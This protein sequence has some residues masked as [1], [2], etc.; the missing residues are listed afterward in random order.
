MVCDRV[1]DTCS[2]LT[3]ACLLHPSIHPTSDWSIDRYSNPTWS[4]ERLRLLKS[5]LSNWNPPEIL[6]FCI[7]LF[8]CRPRPINFSSVTYSLTHSL[9]YSSSSIVRVSEW[10]VGSFKLDAGSPDLICSLFFSSLRLPIVSSIWAAWLA[11]Q[12]T[13]RL[14]IVV[15][16]WS[17]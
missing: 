11:K 9:T 15:W 1:V 8:F 17:Y 2:W 5:V 7:L 10:V 12:P 3:L 14:T 6:H 16:Q 13:T 4:S